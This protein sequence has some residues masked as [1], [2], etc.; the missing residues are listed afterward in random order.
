[1]K[2]E[3]KLQHMSVN[4]WLTQSV[5]MTIH[6]ECMPMIYNQLDGRQGHIRLK[7]VLNAHAYTK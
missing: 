6:K 7:S 5:A 3:Y 1:M 4:L 2:H